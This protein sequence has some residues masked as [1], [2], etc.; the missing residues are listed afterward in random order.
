MYTNR[1]SSSASFLTNEARLTA[2]LAC[3]SSVTHRV[4]LAET[5]LITP[6]SHTSTDETLH[7][8]FGASVTIACAYLRTHARTIA[9]GG[10]LSPYLLHQVAKEY[11]SLRQATSCKVAWDLYGCPKSELDMA[12]FGVQV[13]ADVYPFHGFSQAA[14]ATLL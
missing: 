7:S 13:A 12:N 4:R 14:Y 1:S 2:N 5:D 6:H 3:S 9:G 8:V 10:T 11:R